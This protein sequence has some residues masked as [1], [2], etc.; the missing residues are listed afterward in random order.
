[1]ITL[2]S[3]GCKLPSS[4]QTVQVPWRKQKISKLATEDESCSFSCA[5]HDGDTTYLIH[6]RSNKP[7]S[8]GNCLWEKKTEDFPCRVKV[9]VMGCTHCC[10]TAPLAALLLQLE[11]NSVSSAT[12]G[13]TRSC[14]C[15]A[16]Q[17]TPMGRENLSC[18]TSTFE[19]SFLFFRKNEL[20]WSHQLQADHLSF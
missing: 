7:R 16:T 9:K 20:Q 1:M 8:S 19:A 2:V 11:R 14:A 6:F 13:R 12:R 17:W 3:N 15:Q 18:S 10:R 4:W 5:F